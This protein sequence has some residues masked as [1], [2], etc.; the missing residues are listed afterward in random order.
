MV[1]AEATGRW[2]MRRL[3]C[4]SEE[5]SPGAISVVVVV[6]VVSAAE[7]DVR[8]L[9]ARIDWLLAVMGAAGVVDAS[10]KLTRRR[11]G[12]RERPGAGLG[13]PGGLVDV[14]IDVVTVDNAKLAKAISKPSTTSKF[15][16][17]SDFICN[18]KGTKHKNGS[19]IVFNQP[20]KVRIARLTVREFW[21]V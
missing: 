8:L 6:V 10:V 16:V 5:F 17:S 12:R 15:K 2:K 4:P 20:G 18:H 11:L 19:A 7:T 9:E 21:P 14:D 1:V 3:R 13:D